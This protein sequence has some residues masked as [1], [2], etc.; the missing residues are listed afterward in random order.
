MFSFPKP[1]S[2]TPIN[3]QIIKWGDYPFEAYSLLDITIL[4]KIEGVFILAG[5]NDYGRWIPYYVDFNYNQEFPNSFNKILNDAKAYGAT[6][7]HIARLNDYV[8]KSLLHDNLIEKHNP[9]LNQYDKI[10]KSENNEMPTEN[11]YTEELNETR[12]K[13]EL[14]YKYEA[15]YLELIKNYKE[16]IKF[17]NTMQEDLRRE[18]SQFFTQTLKEVIQT[19]KVAEV[20]KD[21]SAKWVE[22]LVASYTKSID[23]SGDLAKTHVIEIMSL[24][25]GEAKKEATK[26]QLDNFSKSD[27]VITKT[28]AE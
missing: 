25:T 16:E 18:R 2:K 28:D 12:S 8:S 19:M 20:D 10:K 1:A 24:L 21:V 14:L 4:N 15:H 7:I 22:D 9:I 26:A 17:A 5:K 3:P 13:L 11:Q 23:L 27:K 6:H